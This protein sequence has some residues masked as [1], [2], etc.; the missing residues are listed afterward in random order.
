[1][2]SDPVYCP[3]ALGTFSDSISQEPDFIRPNSI[4]FPLRIHC[5]GFGPVTYR[6]WKYHLKGQL[7]PTL[8]HRHSCPLRVLQHT[9]KHTG[10]APDI[11]STHPSYLLSVLQIGHFDRLSP[12]TF[13]QQSGSFANSFYCSLLITSTVKSFAIRDASLQFISKN[14]YPLWSAVSVILRIAR[15]GIEF[16]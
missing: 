10:Y 5:A 3:V 7:I 1:M 9:Y 15:N 6:S 4:Q 16:A 2:C 13:F 12:A 14:S 11:C 8:P